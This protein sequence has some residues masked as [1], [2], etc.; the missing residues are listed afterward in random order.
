MRAKNRLALI[1][2][3][4]YCVVKRLILVYYKAPNL[5]FLTLLIIYWLNYYR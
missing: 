3:V 2:I 4:Y 1:F 5:T